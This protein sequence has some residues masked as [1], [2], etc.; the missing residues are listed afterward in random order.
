MVKKPRMNKTDFWA[1]VSKKDIEAILE[2]FKPHVL[3]MVS[4]TSLCRR[5]EGEVMQDVRLKIWHLLEG[6]RAVKSKNPYT[7]FK[8]SIYNRMRDLIRQDK[9]ERRRHAIEI[10][11]FKMN[12]DRIEEDDTSDLNEWQQ[13][14][15]E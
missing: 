5:P 14:L 2:E 9:F 12:E 15:G 4:K 1:L 8:N 11:Y 13:M 7:Y 10:E 3:A 6:K